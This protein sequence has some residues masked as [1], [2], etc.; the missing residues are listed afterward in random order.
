[1]S[2]LRR[3][4]R[5]MLVVAVAAGFAFI[6]AGQA[7][8][9]AAAPSELAC[10]FSPGWYLLEDENGEL[11]GIMHIDENCKGTAWF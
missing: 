8:A 6:P 10:P 1:M 4:L 5:G 2:A 3:I 7:E 9:S 11:V